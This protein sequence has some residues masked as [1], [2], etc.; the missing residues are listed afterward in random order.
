MTGLSTANLS[1]LRAIAAEMKKNPGG[2]VTFVPLAAPANKPPVPTA[3]S[4][5]RSRALSDHQS[6]SRQTS[7]SIPQSSTTAP[8][9]A[10][11]SSQQQPT[12]SQQ[13]Q[14][15][16]DRILRS[17][18][19]PQRVSSPIDVDMA[20][21]NTAQAGNKPLPNPPSLRVVIFDNVLNMSRKELEPELC[22]VAAWLQPVA[23]DIMRSG[24]LRV[25]CNTPAEA[26]RLLKRDGF[27]ADAFKGRFTVHR[28]GKIDESRPISQH[29]ERDLRSVIT[30]R[31]PIHYDAADLREIFN[32]DYVEDI[33]V[34]PPRDLNRAPLRI[35]VMKTKQL[36]DEAI[37][38]GLQFFNRRINVR[39]LRAPVLP[40]F[41]RKCSGFDHTAVDCKKQHYVCSKC[42][43]NHDTTTCNVQNRDAECPNC[44]EGS[45]GHFATYRGCPAFKVATSKEVERR[46]AR[47]DAKLAARD[48]RRPRFN[49]INNPRSNVPAPVIPGVSFSAA[50]AG[51]HLRQ[52]QPQQPLQLPQQPQPDVLQTIVE[53]LRS[54]RGEISTLNRKITDLEKQQR[55]LH[56]RVEG[57]P[58]FEDD[59]DDEMMAIGNDEDN[60][61]VNNDQHGS[62]HLD[63][64]HG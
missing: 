51:Q 35:L 3:S 17:S 1:N 49:D 48:R 41:C 64:N 38:L 44:P 30:S 37:E 23:V 15:S 18:Q 13:Q 12:G 28:P 27:P 24:G 32:P 8:Q 40:L 59:E 22:R 26:D 50:V 52:Q 9:L 47:I 39:P 42:A 53:T 14:Q 2:N 25:K 16:T 11:A 20:D 7:S 58:S 36:R 31:I 60:N 5:A 57:I 43:G 54:L 46:Q 61:V 4:C 55:R 45:R 62:L 21:P 6:T 63:S 19:Q 33:R 56:E 34:I 29:L 10:S